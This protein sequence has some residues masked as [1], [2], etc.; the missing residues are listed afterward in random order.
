MIAIRG[1]N[2]AMQQFIVYSLIQRSQGLLAKNVGN[3][4][5]SPHRAINTQYP[6]EAILQTG[7][8]LGH[9]QAR[10]TRY[11]LEDGRDLSSG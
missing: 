6:I 8:D 11:Q 7:E 4:W 5:T 9:G 1:E 10:C 3:L 2:G